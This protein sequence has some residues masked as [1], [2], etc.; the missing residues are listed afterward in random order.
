MRGLV[1]VI[2]HPEP[3]PGE[4]LVVRAEAGG[5]AKLGAV[6]VTLFLF[7]RFSRIADDWSAVIPGFN[8][9]GLRLPFITSLVA[10]AIAIGTGGVR[11]ALWS[12]AGTLLSLFTLW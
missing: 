10:F 2:I 1:A 4:E 5:I 7:M 9:A 11:R 3:Q 6:A 8:V 12:R